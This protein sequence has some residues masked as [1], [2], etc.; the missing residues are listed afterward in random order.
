[1][2]IGCFVVL[3]KYEKLSSSRISN[4]DLPVCVLHEY[5]FC[6]LIYSQYMLIFPV[7]RLKLI[8]GERDLIPNHDVINLLFE[9]FIFESMHTG[10]LFLK[11]RTKTLS[12][13]VIVALYQT[14]YSVKT[15]SVCL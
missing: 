13:A 7:H 15:E 10:C 4:E 9:M 3:R 14:Y 12:C 11:T 2:H 1:M 5:R 8:V 6:T